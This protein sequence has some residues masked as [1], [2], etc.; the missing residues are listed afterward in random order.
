ML[1]L[2]RRPLRHA[3]LA[4]AIIFA[5]ASARAEAACG[6]VDLVQRMEREDKNAYEA[7]RAEAAR[8][9]DGE[10]LLWRIDKEG[11]AP[12]YLFG[13]MHVGDPRVLALAD[14]AAPYA[15]AATSVASEV[16][17]MSRTMIAL[18][19]APDLIAAA[20]ADAHLLEL[21]PDP[22][23]RQTLLD[24]AEARGLNAE[25]LDR[26]APWLAAMMFAMPACA[27]QMSE[28]DSVDEHLLDA[29]R[30]AH[31][32]IVA[33]E[34]P[35]EQIAALKT[36]TREDVG[37][38]LNLIAERPTMLE[39]DLATLIGLYL[40]SQIGGAQAALK[41]GLKLKADDVELS[42]E[43]TRRMMSD[44]NVRMAE[45]AS[46]LLDKG[47]AFIAVGAG[48]LS[49]EKGLVALLR[50]KDWRVEKMW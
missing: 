11:V 27:R 12:S 46:P 3:V 39:D 1:F 38:Y 24:L 28:Q 42:E 9:S 48:H 21:V 47:G 7:Y 17:D 6:G 5:P 26:M 2:S 8:V 14:K 29:A 18:A 15:R 33:L 32:P 35:D 23:R 37:R 22:A 25:A 4:L 45:R 19:L 31:R 43:M 50:A 13:T 41:Y 49:G 36:F 40:R 44:R 30:A 20:G 34:K 10:G 16:G